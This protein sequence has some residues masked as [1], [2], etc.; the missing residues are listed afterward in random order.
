MNSAPNPSGWAVNPPLGITVPDFRADGVE[1]VLWVRSKREELVDLEN[2][3]AKA[4]LR[5]SLTTDRTRNMKTTSYQPQ[6]VRSSINSDAFSE[7]T[8]DGML[9]TIESELNIDITQF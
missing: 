7:F 8:L 3:Y 6:N 2:P 1:W 9:G 4:N 5:N